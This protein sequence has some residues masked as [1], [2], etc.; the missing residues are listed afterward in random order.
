VR[1]AAWS[2]LFLA[3]ALAGCAPAP[4]SGPLTD[5][6][7]WTEVAP[8]D[9]PYDDRPEGAGCEPFGWYLEGSVVEVQTDVCRYVTLTQGILRPVEAGET[10]LV[11]VWNLGLWADA[12]A[13]GHVSVQLG[14]A[15]PEEPPLEEARWEA[16]PLIPSPAQ[17]WD[18]ALVAPAALPAGTPIYLH[19]HNHG[20]NSW[21]FGPPRP[22]RPQP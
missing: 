7:R 2:T 3:P 12:R 8:E 10:V 16:F 17:Q 1:V 6:S 9:D 4:P 14:D 21:R 20:A 13:R 18:A 22:P 15:R 11:D 5:P 19:V